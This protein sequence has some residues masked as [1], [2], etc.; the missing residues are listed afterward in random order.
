MSKNKK[1]MGNVDNPKNKIHLN[2]D[3][4]PKV[5]KSYGV[6][7]SVCKSKKIKKTFQN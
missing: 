6:V 7:Q 3:S 2:F 1:R 4:W 5:H